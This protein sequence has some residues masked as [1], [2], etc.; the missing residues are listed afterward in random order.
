MLCSLGGF[1]TVQSPGCFHPILEASLDKFN[2]SQTSLNDSLDE[3]ITELK[4]F[5]AIA[6]EQRRHWKPRNA[7]ASSDIQET[8]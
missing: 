7:P 4:R 8:T 1:F 6:A 3:L 2:K 5:N